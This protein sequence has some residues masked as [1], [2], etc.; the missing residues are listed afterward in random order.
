[1]A[2]YTFV[3]TDVCVSTWKVVLFVG[4]MLMVRG[5]CR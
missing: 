5:V 1:M 3:L 4:V 2:W